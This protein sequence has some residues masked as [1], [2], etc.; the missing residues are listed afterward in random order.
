VRKVVDAVREDPGVRQ[1]LITSY[2]PLLVDYVSPYLS[3]TRIYTRF[4]H[5][6]TQYWR[7][8]FGDIPLP[9]FEGVLNYDTFVG[10]LFQQLM[11][12]RERVFARLRLLGI[13]SS[14]EIDRMVKSLLSEAVFSAVLDVLKFVGEL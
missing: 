12:Y 2:L 3:D 9:D 5:V 6:M 10:R 13:Y 8:V 4:K 7:Q 11:E 14:A 1:I